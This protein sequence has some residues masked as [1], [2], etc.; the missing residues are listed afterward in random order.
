[1]VKL[2][3][4]A[5]FYRREVCIKPY[6]LHT[7]SHLE[8]VPSQNPNLIK[9]IGK[10][11]YIYIQYQINFIKSIV[12]YIFIVNLFCDEN[13]SNVE[14]NLNRPDFEKKNPKMTLG[15]AGFINAR[16]ETR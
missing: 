13:I 9:F 11:I 15:W 16:N 1:M 2:M 4:F 5:N 10:P 3:P 6:S 8:Y 7:V 14:L 12:K